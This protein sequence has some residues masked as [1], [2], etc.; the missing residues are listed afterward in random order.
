MN[1]D[2]LKL[3]GLKY[4]AAMLRCVSEAGEILTRA[5][6]DPTFDCTPGCDIVIHTG[7]TMPGLEAD[8]PEPVEENMFDSAVT[9][10]PSTLKHID[11]HPIEAWT[12]PSFDQDPDKYARAAGLVAQ[13][14]SPAAAE[15]EQ[16]EPERDVSEASPEPAGEGT[17]AARECAAPV[18]LDPA[19]LAQGVWSAE[20]DTL[21]IE[22][23]A[24]QMFHAG[25]SLNAAAEIAAGVLQRPVQG[26]Q[27]RAKAGLKG[28]IMARLAERKAGNNV[29][30]MIA[31]PAG[32]PVTDPVRTETVNEGPEDAKGAQALPQAASEPVV[33]G[34]G[35]PLNLHGLTEL[36]THVS[37]VKRDKVWTL[38]R[39]RDLLHFAIAGWPDHEIA[40]ELSVPLAEIKPR[41]NVLTRARTFKRDY[42]LAALE[43]MLSAQAAA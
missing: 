26:T 22:T 41:F 29:E 25:L 1:L 27:F 24:W 18:T 42:V 11:G 37:Q 30:N 6:L 40:L 34:T 43:R 13:S 8:P 10:S 2:N 9:L 20:E 17:G 12:G 19:P 15:P 16:P 35:S 23:C 39:D 38:Q 36:E 28:R 3:N 5:G 7:W 14:P 21:L 31:I 33:A 4:L 32:P